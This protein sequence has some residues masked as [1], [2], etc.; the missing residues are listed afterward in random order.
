MVGG[1]NLGSK[2]VKPGAPQKKSEIKRR[3]TIGKTIKS[4]IK[5]KIRTTNYGKAA[6]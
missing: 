6:K 2:P 3:T 5:I 1:R 4:R